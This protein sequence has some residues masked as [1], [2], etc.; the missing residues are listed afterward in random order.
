MIW[1][2]PENRLMQRKCADSLLQNDE[3]ICPSANNMWN[4]DAFIFLSQQL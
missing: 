3:A 2:S 1:S 4:L